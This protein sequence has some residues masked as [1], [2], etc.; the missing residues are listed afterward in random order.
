MRRSVLLVAVV[1]LA[2][3][4]W[5]Q[6]RYDAGR[7]A[8]SPEALPAELRLQW[9]RQLPPTQPAFWLP[10]QERVQFDLG[11]EPIVVGQTLLVGSSA[12]DCLRAIDTRSGN[13]RWTFFAEGP[14]RL[15]PAAW[16]DRVFVGSDDGCVYAL[17]I[18]DGKLLWKQ[19]IVPSPRKVLGNGRMISVWP[20]R[21]GPVVAD[22][23]VFVA[24]G[25]WPFEGIFI[26]AI[27]AASGNVVW[28]NDR[29]GSL[30]AAHPHGG[31]SF[32]GPSPQGYLLVQGN[33]LVVPSGRAFPAFFDRASGKLNEFE[34]GYAGHG[35]VPAAWFVAT[36]PSGE[37]VVDRDLSS[38][39]HDAGRQILGQ[40]GVRH[41]PGEPLRDEITIGTRRYHIDEHAADEIHAGDRR[42]RFADKL[43]G[44]EGTIHSIIAADQRLFVVNRAGML[45]CLGAGK[46]A[47]VSRNPF[48]DDLDLPFPAGPAPTIDTDLVRGLRGQKGY[49]VVL[50]AG[51]ALAR[52][53][54]HTLLQETEYQVIVLTRDRAAAEYWRAVRSTGPKASRVAYLV[55]DGDPELPPYFASLVVGDP[56]GD[57]N[58]WLAQFDPKAARGMIARWLRPFGGRA[59]LKLP[60]AADALLA[61]VGVEL[62][63]QGNQVEATRTGALTGAADYFGR[64]NFDAL[65]RAPMGLLWYGDTQFHHKLFY[66]G[67]AF[68]AGRGLP[69]TIRVAHGIMNYRVPAEPLG[70][71]P[72]DTK[73][74]V[75]LDY[76]NTKVNYHETFTDIYTGRRLE[77]GEAEPF[78]KSAAKGD[79][80]PTAAVPVAYTRRNPLTGVL[81]GRE[82]QKTYGCDQFP[83]DYG[84]VYTMRS[85]TGA[86]YDAAIE[87]GTINVSGMR[88]GCR[89]SIVPAGGIL[90]LPQWTG[91]CTCNYPLFTSLALVHMP[92]SFEQWTAWGGAAVT[93][94]LVRGGINF[95]APGDRMTEDGTLWLDWPSVGGPSPDVPVEIDPPDCAT[96]YKHA[97]R[98]RGGEGWPWVVASGLEGVR[99]IR[100]TPMVRK[101]TAPVAGFAVRWSGYFLPPADGDYTFHG[102]T[103]HGLRLWIDNLAVLDSGKNVRRGQQVEI[104]GK[105]GLKAGVRALIRGEYFH[106]QS[107]GDSAAVSLAVSGP[108]LSKQPLGGPMVLTS[109]G[110]PGGLVGAYY[111]NYQFNGPSVVR[112]DPQLDFTWGKATPEPLGQPRTPDRKERTFTVRLYFAEPDA[113]AT[114][115]SRV[116][117]VRLQGQ[118]V[119]TALD[120]AREA[121]GPLR[122]L[123][124][125]FPNV[126]VTDQLRVEFD[127]RAGKPI[128]CGLELLLPIQ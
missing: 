113:A 110:K 128:V 25:V 108:G 117:D 34:F 2:G 22:G 45:H 115:G 88:S 103:D 98:M 66:A 12:D 62:I 31:L 75:Y 82:F 5:P 47:S 112:I 8:R 50:G 120:V 3:A 101:T 71:N 89:N 59:R 91:N 52:R 85:A 36:R 15:A 70:A 86:F 4:D 114:A 29:S 106:P 102:R 33:E 43:S 109:D 13:T 121:G 84:G 95:G 1:L 6:W 116:F 67:I 54:V 127:Q 78:L 119:A 90:S 21:G 32:G 18:A 39:I 96:F 41:K 42:F 28:L 48:T 74:Q 37:L 20:V 111:E 40:T 99:T 124:R 63:S 26:A 100:L 16:N 87:S 97:V 46:P 126:V 24:A 23:K 81:E 105:I 118:A 10:R 61:D 14:I 35:S 27:D 104:T 44:V 125:S 51:G 49:A 64:Q 79:G 55:C 80:L 94:P 11:Y 92:E 60:S 93:A 83:V 77:P 7:T 57:L 122:G 69:Q 38:E 72:P 76:L 19:R 17:A 53:T 9:T 56:E 68:E 107:A 58:A 30:Y 65:V 73:Y 123:V